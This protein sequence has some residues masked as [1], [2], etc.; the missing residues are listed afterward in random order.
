MIL[1]AWIASITLSAIAQTSAAP[2]LDNSTASGPGAAMVAPPSEAE[3]DPA[4]T[5]WTPNVVY[6]HTGEVDLQ[7]DL[8]QPSDGDS[9]PYPCIVIMHGGAWRAGN[10]TIHDDL[11]RQLAARGYVAATISYRLCPQYVFPAQVEDAK[12]A[13]R[14]L[15]AHADEYNIDPDHFGAIGF[16]AGA[17]LAMMLGALDADEGMEG[18]GGWTGQPSK[19]QAVVSFFGPTDFI[20]ELPEGSSKLVVDFLGGTAQ[21]KPDAYRAASP[22]S[23]VNRGD[24]PMLLF[25]GTRDNLVPWQQATRMA[26]ALT[27]AGVPGRVELL[28]G[29]GHGWMGPDLLRTLQEGVTFFDDHLKVAPKRIP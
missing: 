1:E 6:G 29:Q 5:I 28:V 25:Q 20:T 2:G 26:E 12:C 22:L 27:K 17:H 15:R 9:G 8:A 14:F 11:A 4:D 19:V 10:R 7:L 16:S 21:E 13:V 18:D 23:H 24:A 3:L